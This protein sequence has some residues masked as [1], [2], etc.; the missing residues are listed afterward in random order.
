MGASLYWLLDV[1]LGDGWSDL[2]LD[3]DEARRLSLV[4]DLPVE[5][6]SL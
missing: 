2:G 5:F 6:A 3:F 1:S 4:R